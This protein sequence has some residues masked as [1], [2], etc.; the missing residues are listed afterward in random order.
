MHA[1]AGPIAR[2]WGLE[3]GPDDVDVARD[4]FERATRVS[5]DHAAWSGY[6]RSMLSSN[7]FMFLD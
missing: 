6:V 7:L 4:Y 3:P 1:Y 2:F 5:S